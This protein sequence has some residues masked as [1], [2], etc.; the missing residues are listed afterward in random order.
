MFHSDG[1]ASTLSENF[2]LILFY[3][4]TKKEEQSKSTV[5]HVSGKT[6]GKEKAM[7]VNLQKLSHIKKESHTRA[8]TSASTTGMPRDLKRPEMVLFPEEIPPVSP[9]TLII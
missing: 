6:N 5:W 4:F 2:L 3:S 8:T 9:M 1:T 7:D